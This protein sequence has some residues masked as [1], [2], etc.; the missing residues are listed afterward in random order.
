MG[1]WPSR[2]PLDPEAAGGA[3][4]PDR[5]EVV[6]QAELLSDNAMR[7]ILR[8]VSAAAAIGVAV[9][10]LMVYALAADF[11]KTVRGARPL[12]IA[13]AAEAS[14]ELAV[15]GCVLGMWAWRGVMVRTRGM[16]WSRRRRR[17]S[18]L[19]AFEGL[20]LLVASVF[21]LAPNVHALTRTCGFFD[22]FV[23][24]SA[25]VRF[26][27]WAT[28]YAS[29]VVRVRMAN[30]WVDGGG[31]RP[32]G[33]GEGLIL[34]APWGRHAP[35]A[36]YWAAFV[37]LGLAG[38]G[39]GDGVDERGGGEAG[40]ACEEE[41]REC[42][43]GDRDWVLKVS[44]S[45]MSWGYFMFLVVYAGRGARQLHRKSYSAFRWVFSLFRYQCHTIGLVFTL[46][47]VSETALAFARYDSCT[48]YAATTLG[49]LSN[50]LMVGILGVLNVLLFMPTAAS[51]KAGKSS[52]FGPKE[53]SPLIWSER[54]CFDSG[55][56]QGVAISEERASPT[57]GRTISSGTTEPS[58]C[59]ETAVKLFY[60]SVFAYMY[61]PQTGV[62]DSS[63]VPFR[64]EVAI[65]LY[66]IEN[67][68][69]IDSKVMDM[70]CFVGWNRQV[71]VVAVRG[72]KTVGE[73]LGL[74]RREL[75]ELGRMGSS[76]WEAEREKK[77]REFA[78]HV[79]R[80]LAPLAA[81]MACCRDSSS[82]TASEQGFPDDSTIVEIVD[83]STQV[84]VHGNWGSGSAVSGVGLD[85]KGPPPR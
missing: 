11:F 16:A 27:C 85:G 10:V 63:A 44:T 56:G 37:A 76:V 20:L 26:L 66:N 83:A 45:G 38:L 3:G 59:F 39:G 31:R 48:A 8:C 79:E 13:N 69:F 46:S 23:K 65:G 22:G 2:P 43:F 50:Q 54:G 70:R 61:D 30:L 34:D 25:G 60:W 49:G 40:E 9:A 75:L 58:F 57:K 68:E 24:W 21:F 77:K 51:G 5:D 29:F 35:V 80:C 52:I 81:L 12:M 41:V 6:M 55:S 18:C 7:S 74:D 84:T 42:A 17:L 32:A 47:L 14:I 62:S 73:A 28:L 78:E 72:T 64:K 1:G 53:D 4:A 19:V 15:L 71:V 33:G 82:G 67:L 36:L